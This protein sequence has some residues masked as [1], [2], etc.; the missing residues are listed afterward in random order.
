MPQ[1]NQIEKQVVGYT[2]FTTKKGNLMSVFHCVG[3]D[4]RV[5]GMATEQ[6]MVMKDTVDVQ[7]EDGALYGKSVFIK[8]VYNRTGFCVEC[9]IYNKG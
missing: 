9:I 1:I 6:I 3:K 2:E 4:M 7:T 5:Q 8:P